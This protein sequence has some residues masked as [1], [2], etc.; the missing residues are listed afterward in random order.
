MAN[1]KKAVP[2]I[3]FIIVFSVILPGCSTDEEKK[4]KH[5]EKGT[6]YFNNNEFK[7]AEIE[8][9]NAVQIDP[10]NPAPFFQSRLFDIFK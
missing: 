6:A 5:F 8:F 10:N 2:F 1:L 9:K 3:L 7:N 4:Q